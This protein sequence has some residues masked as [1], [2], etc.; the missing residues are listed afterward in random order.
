MTQPQFPPLF[1]GEAAKGDP[2]ALACGRAAEGC[3][4]GLVFYDLAPD[5]LRAAIVFAPETA[6]HD[7]LAALPVCGVGFQN[8]LGALGPPEV[9][10]HLGWDGPIYVNGGRCGALR[11]AASPK[12]PMAEPDWLVVGLD[13]WLWPASEEGGLTPDQTALY[14]E[15]CAEVDAVELLEAWVRHT[16][17]GLNAWSDSGLASLHREWGGLAHGKGTDIDVLGHAGHFLGVDEHFG[18]LLRQGDTTR[19][20]PL[21]ELLEDLP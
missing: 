20:I 11:V 21:T 2:F 3:D 15:G 17:V 1:S 7:A 8:A 9:A 4:A 6:L 16:L 12:D 5:R 19:L 14:A 10:V 13:L 18:L